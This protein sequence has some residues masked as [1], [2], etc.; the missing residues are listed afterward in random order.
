MKV[1]ERPVRLPTTVLPTGDL[2]MSARDSLLVALPAALLG[3]A[4]GFFLSQVLETTGQS[5]EA[6]VPSVAGPRAPGAETPGARGTTLASLPDSRI[7]L[8]EVPRE[9]PK[10]SS[11]EFEN[12]ASGVTAPTQEASAGS[13]QITGFVYDEDGV[14]MANVLLVASKRSESSPADPSRE[15][16]GPPDEPGLKEHL[17]T[18]ADQW[19]QGRANRNRASTDSLGAFTIQ[20]LDHNSRFS[21]TAYAQDFSFRREGNSGWVTPETEVIFRAKRY[22]QI[23]LNIVN[24]DGTPLAGPGAISIKRG[25]RYRVFAWSPEQPFVRLLSGRVSLQALAGLIGSPS[26]RRVQS[27]SLASDIEDLIVGK[28]EE[29]T[30]TLELHARVGISGSLTDEGTGSTSGFT[31]YLL[32]TPDDGSFDEDAVRQQGVR[33]DMREGRFAF[34]DLTAGTYAVCVT[35]SGGRVAISQIVKVDSELV[36]LDLVIPAPDASE[37]VQVT[38]TGPD[39]RT[40]SDLQFRFMSQYSSGSSSGDLSPRQVHDNTYWLQPS[41]E[42]FDTW[43]AGQSFK[44]T[45]IHPDLGSREVD[46][47]EGQRE[48]HVALEEPVSILVSVSDYAGSQFVGKLFVNAVSLKEDGRGSANP[49]DFRDQNSLNAKG[50]LHLDGLSPGNWEIQ[51]CSGVNRWNARVID[52]QEVNISAGEKSVIFDLPVLYSQVII[53]PDLGAGTSLML[54]PDQ[55]DAQGSLHYSSGQD[56]AQVDVDGRAVFEGLSAG[57]YRLSGTSDSRKIL[58]TVPGGEYYLETSSPDALRVSIGDLEGSLA[59]A[60]LMPGDLIIGSDGKEFDS[61]GNYWQILTGEG[62]VELMVLRQ[63]NRIDIPFDRFDLGAYQDMGGSLQPVH[64]D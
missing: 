34:L 42:F 41:E 19:A 33:G 50:E 14:P 53:A 2:R 49:L 12:A 40:L 5:V 52:A 32:V 23:T 16:A 29:L 20:G 51:L 58:I 45:V 54:R 13:G 38:A 9:A 15:G 30:L 64:R 18:S 44:L 25:D 1:G 7:P 43:Q 26:S 62:R 27:S 48:V 56:W 60:G 22:H 37:H 11:R 21:V 55:D 39:G 46:L 35:T 57:I 61:V 6:S 17:Q 24:A 3:V 36:E 8:T 28:T 4:L 47:E 10:V 59:K 31:T 63:G